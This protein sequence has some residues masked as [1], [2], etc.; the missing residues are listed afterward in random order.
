MSICRFRSRSRLLAAAF[1]WTQT[2]SEVPRFK[3]FLFAIVGG[4]DGPVLSGGGFGIPGGGF[5]HRRATDVV[6]P[7]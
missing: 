5:R 7:I 2:T 6:P 1:A 4:I 3:E